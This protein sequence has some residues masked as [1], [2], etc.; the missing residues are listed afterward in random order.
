MEANIRQS[1]LEGVGPAFDPRQ[2]MAVRDKTRQAIVL[3]AAAMQP[4]MLEE[5]A[6]EQAKDIL[7]ERGMLR[8][9]HDVYVRFGRNTLKTFGAA[10]DPGVRLG[11]DDIFF[12]DIGPVWKQ[13]EGDGGDSFVTGADPEMARCAADARATARGWEL[14]LDLSGHRLADFPHAAI[15]EGPLAEVDFT[16]ARMLWVLE[17]HIRH[18]SR[19]FGAFFEDMLLEDAC[20][21]E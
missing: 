5:D 13:W 7:A 16:P 4:G 18:P 3:I 9:W 21:A 2:L 8:G 1:A 11:D 17:I 6:V 14:N 15:H 12:I 19:P 10:S 20:F